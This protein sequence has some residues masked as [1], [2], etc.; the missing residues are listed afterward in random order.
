MELAQEIGIS[1]FRNDWQKASISILYTYGF[2]SNGHEQFFKRH[3]LT[4]QQYNV[5]RILHDQFPKPVSTSFLREKMLDKMSDASRLVNRLNVKGLVEVAQNSTDKR[6]VNIL[7]SGE[8]QKMFDSIEGDLPNLDALMQGLTLEE[9]QQLTMLLDK[10]RES[11]MSL[12]E[13]TSTAE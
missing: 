8:G 2:M 6:L 7:I 11:I 4:S 3:G 13:R 12:E 9:A 10:V 1:S 5:L